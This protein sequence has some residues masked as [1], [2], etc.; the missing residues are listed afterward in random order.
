MTVTVNA[1]DIQRWICRTH[2]FH[3]NVALPR[4]TTVEPLEAAGGRFVPN[5]SIYGKEGSIVRR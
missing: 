1:M 4:F 2:R 5:S 3:F